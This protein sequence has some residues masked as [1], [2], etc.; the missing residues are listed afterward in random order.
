MIRNAYPDWS[1]YDSLVVVMHLP[2]S[3]GMSLV[4]RVD[5]RKSRGDA[6]DR[7]QTET[8]LHSG[9]NR[10]ALSLDDIRHGPL[11]RT[12]DLHDIDVV[13]INGHAADVG[14]TVWLEEIRLD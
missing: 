3:T 10:I 1:G 14:R 5:D 9:L 2:D 6:T 11:T 7:F 12:L 4:L 13:F 8:L